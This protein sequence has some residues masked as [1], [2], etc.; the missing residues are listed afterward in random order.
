[1]NGMAVQGNR[2]ELSNETRT[3]GGSS[4]IMLSCKKCT[5]GNKVTVEFPDVVYT[6]HAQ[7]LHDARCDE[8]AA[9]NAATAICQQPVSFVH[10]KEVCLCNIPLSTPLYSILLPNIIYYS[11]SY[12]P[13]HSPSI[14]HYSNV[15]PKRCPLFKSLSQTLS[16]TQTV[17][18]KHYPC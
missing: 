9:R 5:H 12:S 1:M 6:F 16:N 4:D 18:P 15:C 3:G 13:F 8:G 10:V 7:W 2:M 14:V 17:F 11:N